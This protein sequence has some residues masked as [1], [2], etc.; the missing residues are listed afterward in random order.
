M[1]GRLSRREQLF[2][3]GGGLIA[4][5]LL[6]VAVLE[7]ALNSL[8]GYDARIAAKQA[9]IDRARQVQQRLMVISGQLQLRQSRL[10]RQTSGSIFALI[11]ATTVR[12]GCRDNLAAMRPQPTTLRE[13]VRVEPVELRLDNIALEQLARLLEAFD[14]ADMLLNVRSLKVRRRFD[15]PA[16]LDVTMTVEAL[17]SEG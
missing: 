14:S 3:L 9:E 17:H 10:S 13:G 11:E 8:G 2:L 4:A 6:I 16:R 15:A 7:P 12:L 5:L 1:I